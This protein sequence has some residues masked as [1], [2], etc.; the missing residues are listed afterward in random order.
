MSKQQC[1]ESDVNLFNVRVHEAA[2]RGNIRCA[3]PFI[4]FVEK[5]SRIFSCIDT[6]LG[7]VEASELRRQFIEDGGEHELPPLRLAT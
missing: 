7:L 3:S 4:N 5:A 2:L 6:I 1:I